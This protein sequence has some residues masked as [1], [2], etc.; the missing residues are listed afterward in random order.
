MWVKLKMSETTV[1]Q[2]RREKA[3]VLL[4]RFI[5]FNVI[6]FTVFLIGTVIFSSFFS[7]FGPWTWLIANGVGSVLQFSLITYFNKKKGGVIFDQCPEK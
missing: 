7:Y 4:V 2:S 3:K 1:K 5:K 6:G